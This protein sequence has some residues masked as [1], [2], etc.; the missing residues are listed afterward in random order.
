M[1]ELS[2]YTKAN[3]NEYIEEAVKLPNLVIFISVCDS[4]DRYWDRF[5]NRHLLGLKE[6]LSAKWRMSYL[7]VIDKGNDVC[8]E[9]LS[10]KWN[11]VESSYSFND[12]DR[13]AAHIYGN[14]V[15]EQYG[16]IPTENHCWLYSC[17]MDK[18]KYTRSSIVINGIDYSLNK[19]GLNIVLYSKDKAVVIDSVNVDTFG[20]ENLTVRRLAV[21]V[22]ERKQ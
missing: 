1:E 8:S 16:E 6:D 3:L 12:S 17:A 4:A 5:E 22:K 20:D 14:E 21:T 2:I 19:R 15:S 18:C 10:D 13:S 7:A 11:G 9:L